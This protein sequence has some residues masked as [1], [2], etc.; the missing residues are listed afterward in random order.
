MTGDQEGG[1]VAKAGFGTV[2]EIS[3]CLRLSRATLYKLMDA[4][5]LPYVK[6][7]RSRRI[8]WHAVERLVADNTVR[9]SK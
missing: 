6:I 2:R 3:E 5:S 1:E 9:N 4:G 7:G 8:G